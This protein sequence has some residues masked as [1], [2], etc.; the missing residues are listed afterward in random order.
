MPAFP[1]LR[2]QRVASGTAVLLWSVLFCF[3]VCE[4]PAAVAEPRKLVD[5]SRYGQAKMVRVA[6]VLRP[7]LAVADRVLIG[8]RWGWRVGSDLVAA[9][10]AEG[11]TIQPGPPDTS[12]LVVDLPEGSDILAVAQRFRRR[13]DVAF[14][15][16]D[17]L[18]YTTLTPSDP[19]YPL[20]THLPQ[21]K[22]PQAWDVSTGNSSVVIAI[23]DTGV[24]TSHPDLEDRIWTNPGEIPGN[25]IDDDRNGYV[26]D[27]HGWNFWDENNDVVPRPDGIDQNYDGEADEQVNHGTLSAG[28]AAAAANGVG[29]VGVTWYAT[30]MPL[31]VFPDDGSTYVSTVV[32]AME[33]AVRNGAYVMNLSLGSM[34][35][36]AFT[37]P[38]VEMWSRGGL[39]VSAAGNSGEQ[40]TDSESTWASPA[41][42]DGNSPLLENM[43]IGVG[44]VDAYDRKAVW[45]NYDGSSGKHFVDVFAPGVDLYGPAM[46][47]PSL[48]AFTTLYTRNSGTSFSAPLVAGLV[49]LLKGHAPGMSNAA[50]VQAIRNSADNLDAANPGY[51]GKMGA[52]RVNAARTLGVDLP[53]Q[54]VT[55]YTARDRTGD[56]GGAC[57]LTWVKSADDGGGAMSVTGYIVSRAE[58][59]LPTDESGWTDIATLPPGSTQY[60][61]MTTVDG[62][63]YWYRVA[64]I[65]PGHRV[66]SPVAG[67]VTSR[68]DLPPPKVLTL[69]VRDHPGDNGGA[70]DLDWTGYEGSSDLV[71][72]AIYRHT[73][74]FR[75][76]L[77]LTPLTILSDPDARTYTDS[78]T[79]DGVDYYYAVVGVDA[80][81]NKEWDVTATGPVQS[82]GNMQVR[83]AAG[84]HMLASPVVPADGHPATLFGIAPETL[85]YA[86]YDPALSDYVRYSGEPLPD[87]LRV[88]LGQGFWI[89][90]DHEVTASA[91]GVTAPAGSVEVTLRPG[92]QQ[93]G[94][95]YLAPMQF[96]A[97]TVTYA[98]NTMDLPSA[99]SQGIMRSYGWVY[100]RTT[101]EYELV[102]ATLGNHPSIAPWEGFW[103]LAD[104]TCTLT[105]T[106]PTGTAPA[107]ATS[108]TV[109]PAADGGWP[110]QLVA[111]GRSQS[112]SVNYFG[113]SSCGNA[114]ENPPRLGPGPELTFVEVSGA[115]PGARCATSFVA[116]AQADMRWRFN[117]DWQEAQGTVTLS[118]PDLSRV[119]RD[120]DLYLHDL[121]QDKRVSMRQ[122]AGY[123]VDATESAGTRRFAIEASRRR[124][125]PAL[126]TALS[127]KPAGQGSQ[128]VFT[129][130]KP[131]SCTVAVMNIA[132]RVVREVERDRL[133]GA[134]TQT[135]AWDGRSRDGTPVPAGVYLVKVTARGEDGTVTS[136]LRNI[137]L[138]R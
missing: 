43:N 20:Q 107:T 52:G 15:Q 93:V 49:A 11:G 56:N 57:L 31:R 118:W 135:A 12:L 65:A 39:T 71:A 96:A 116:S 121:D 117:V 1:A 78:T 80:H 10:R 105:L 30:I 36:P 125:G 9:V 94:N 91:D 75:S 126:V 69:V 33:Y 131:A 106:R 17:R 34:F 24:Y 77:G 50:I 22:C 6:G 111:R 70:M 40:I 137:R 102:H 119:P 129:L 73:R 113:V 123:V 98:G 29:T 21:I 85:R 8:V 25:G 60:V 81:G 19:D 124:T 79:Q 87:F 38:V 72:F 104:K 44:S 74:P 23:I 130:S 76:I 66:E 112:D 100:D 7:N 90:F 92:W 110:V 16:P 62:T 46:Y 99:E 109:R 2:Q 58:G 120:Y 134:G 128:V 51:A 101:G 18:V 53:P 32:R 133:R 3:V 89:M 5:L 48:P 55:E 95:P 45:S 83:F 114:I 122:Q 35:D 59:T 26:D 37:A 27:V 61:D 108:A 127:V 41:C 103:V 82:F 42:N 136:A 13:P 88:R 138:A 68:D 67:P 4:V 54:P 63:D 14:A 28:L 86:R 84:L 47:F 64:T 115:R 97:L 132:G